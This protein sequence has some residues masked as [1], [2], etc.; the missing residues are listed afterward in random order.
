MKSGSERKKL[1]IVL[2]AD[3]F[4]LS[5]RLPHARAAEAEGYKVVVVAGDT[6]VGGRIVE[7][8]FE[9]YSITVDRSGRN[10]FHDFFTFLQLLKIYKEI[11]PD[12]IHH[13][14]WKPL[15]YGTL[16]GRISGIPRII[17]TVT[18]FGYLFIERSDRVALLSRILVMLLKI[19]LKSKRVKVIVQNQDDYNTFLRWGIVPECRLVKINGA[20]VDLSIFKYSKENTESATIKIVLPARIIAD[21]GVRDFVEAADYLK[22][23][24]G[25]DIDVILAGAIDPE[26]ISS[27][28]A[29][30][31]EEIRETGNVKWAGFISDMA[32]F[33][34]ECHII[35]LPSYREGLPKVLLEAF[36]SGRPV[37][38]TDV[39]GCRD[40]VDHQQNGLI[41][42]VNNP[43]ALAQAIEILVVDPYKR[44]EMGING[45]AKAEDSFD[46]NKVVRQI[47]NFYRSEENQQKN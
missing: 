41:V 47:L 31:L 9:F 20:G 10:V 15:L 35:V 14:T 19:V 3:W 36:A 21:K 38:T 6:G 1:L 22:P 37:V 30:E 17:N 16:A 27:L 25:A 34:K 11:R 45:R 46:V 5:H 40:V 44:N 18:G 43:R 33:M 28:T 4:F 13:F 39:P 23:K 42:P 8:G 32:S 2:N 26:N 24:Y 29:E 12:I 7:E